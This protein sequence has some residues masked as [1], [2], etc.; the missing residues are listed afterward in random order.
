MTELTD[1]Q[2]RAR[3]DSMTMQF[4]PANKRPLRRVFVMR[5]LGLFAAPHFSP[6]LMLASHRLPQQRPQYRLRLRARPPVAR[7]SRCVWH[8]A[9]A[10]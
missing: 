9:S 6:V 5:T 10:R 7:N 4:R 1:E 2:A 8:S 3:I